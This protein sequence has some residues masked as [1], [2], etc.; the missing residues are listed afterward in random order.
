LQI[1][2]IAADFKTTYST[3]FREAPAA[4][5]SLASLSLPAG[6]FLI[7]I[8]KSNDSDGSDDAATWLVVLL[9]PIDASS[10]EIRVKI[11][12]RRSS[13]Y[14]AT[15]SNFIKRCQMMATTNELL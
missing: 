1:A 10:T 14:A 7:R 13:T 8:P 9:S 2:T 4:G 11:Q 12:S 6:H 5:W 3:L 15:V